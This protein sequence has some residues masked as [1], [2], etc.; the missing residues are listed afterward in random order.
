MS[1]RRW[2]SRSSGLARGHRAP[3]WA[4]GFSSSSQETPRAPA[5][6]RTTSRAPS[7]DAATLLPR[8]RT[9]ARRPQHDFPR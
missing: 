6:G 2:M 8:R 1:R 4:G 3:C 5:A 9:G 7:D